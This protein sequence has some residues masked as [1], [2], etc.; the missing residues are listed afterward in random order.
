[1]HVIEHDIALTLDI[2]FAYKKNGKLSPLVKC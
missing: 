1:M 2:M